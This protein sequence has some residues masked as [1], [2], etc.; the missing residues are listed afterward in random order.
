MVI[1]FSLAR[2]FLMAGLLMVVIAKVTLKHYSWQRQQ[3]LQGSPLLKLMLA[4]HLV[5]HSN[6]HCSTPI[7]VSLDRLCTDFVQALAMDCHCFDQLDLRLH[8][9]S[10]QKEQ[11]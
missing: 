3:P 11:R 4:P 6:L 1:E 8:P 7:L 10:D 9:I 2:R 5:I